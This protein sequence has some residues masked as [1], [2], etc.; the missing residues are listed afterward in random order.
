MAVA[1]LVVLAR[2]YSGVR[3][4]LLEALA[5]LINSGIVPVIPSRGSVGASGDLTPLS[6]LGALL[7]GEREALVDGKV[8]PGAEALARCGLE[9]YRFGIK[10]G[11]ALIN[12]TS[13]MSAVG[14]LAAVRARRL[15]ER[16]EQASA[17]A[18]EVTGGRSSAMH[19]TIHRVKPHAGQ[20]ASAAGILADLEGSGL[21]RDGG[22]G[23]AGDE[24]Q[25]RYCLRC[26]PQL[27]GAARDALAWVERM[28][29]AEINA[30]SDNPIVDPESGEI[31]NGGN[32]YGGHVALAMDLLKI[33]AVT[34]INLLD[35]QF[36]YLVSDDN[37]HCPETLLPDGW[38]PE[39]E[40]GLHHGLKALQITVSSLA[41]LAQQKVSP[42]SVLS[43][44]TECDNQDVVSMGT[45]AAIN[46]ASVLE[47]GE[48]ALACWLIALS[49]A[50][51][52][53]GEDGLSPAGRTLVSRIRELVPV[54]TR[55]RELDRDIERLAGW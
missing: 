7:A 25:D 55:D 19:P 22:D 33:S 3:L 26:A 9:P 1:R 8:V 24:I 41:A 42:D 44:Q 30:V 34:V 38:L 46:A 49:Q 51:A 18:I 23:D 14:A 15:I 4:A 35:R 45:N 10:E 6:Y 48:Q 40:K 52:V 28:V 27:L 2:G 21:A 20:A 53:R 39:Q 17:L 50:A 29:E 36:A 5:R 54:V 43:R 31:H 37:P 13:V 32:F 16:A 11:L 47:L 12:G